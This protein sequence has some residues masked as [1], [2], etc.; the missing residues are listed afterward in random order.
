[1]AQQDPCCLCSVGM[2]GQCRDMQKNVARV[3]TLSIFNAL[4]III[5]PFVQMGKLE[6]EE[7]SDWLKV[8]HNL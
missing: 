4:L 5:F 7:M 8:T 3:I 6:F 1:M 2:Q